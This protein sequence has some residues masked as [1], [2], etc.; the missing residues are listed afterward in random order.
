[1]LNKFFGITLS[2]VLALG[3]QVL[4]A[5]AQTLV[6]VEGF[7]KALSEVVSP[8]LATKFVDSGA[9]LSALSVTEA[10]AIVA[11]LAKLSV[12]EPSL[13]A[14]IET[15]IDSCSKKVQDD[16]NAALETAST[17]VKETAKATNIEGQENVAEEGKVK[18]LNTSVKADN[19]AADTEY[20]INTK[21]AKSLSV[22]A[23]DLQ[24]NPVSEEAKEITVIS[25]FNDVMTVAEAVSNPTAKKDAVRATVNYFNNTTVFATMIEAGKNFM[26]DTINANPAV[27]GDVS[28]EITT[29]NL[30]QYSDGQNP[31][32]LTCLS[33]AAL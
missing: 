5:Q 26:I 12:N 7:G 31:E 2:V 30:Y 3:S 8:E 1:M 24:G 15:Y 27:Y 16:F 17:N 9:Q 25:K 23:N 32:A 28:N 18:I 14:S 22:D 13:K 29:H 11:G 20:T 21:T 4:F 10:S 6:E 33:R 19:E